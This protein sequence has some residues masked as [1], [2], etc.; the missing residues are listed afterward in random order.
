MPSALVASSILAMWMVARWFTPALAQPIDEK[1]LADLPLIRVLELKGATYH[2]QGVDSNSSQVWLTSVD[3]AKRIGYLQEFSLST[4]DLSR[5]VKLGEGVRFHPGGIDGDAKSMW[6]PV[7]E[8]RRD[9]TSVIEQRNRHTLELEF[10]FQVADHIGCVAVMPE[11]VVGGNW[12]SRIFYIWD[13]RGHLIRKVPNP[14][15]NAYQ[16]MKFV[17]GHIVASGLLPGRRGAIDWLEFPLLR[18][19][20]R[21]MAGVTDRGEPFTREGMAIRDQQ[22]LLLPEDGPS[23]LFIF[24]LNV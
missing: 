3:T 2:V 4:G 20:R 5:K 23:L 22:L 9:S 10:Q 11:F 15:E 19:R 12:D 13:H 21:M 7:A 1:S 14:S 16:D 24:R 6:I 17:A 18:V 8:Y